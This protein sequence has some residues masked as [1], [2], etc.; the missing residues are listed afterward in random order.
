MILFK[1]CSDFTSFITLINCQKKGCR[2]FMA[3]LFRFAIFCKINLRLLLLPVHHIPID[4]DR[5][6]PG[7]IFERITVVEHDVSIFAP[8]K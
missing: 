2:L 3:T 8:F 5:F 4:N 1:Y 6:Y 7:Q